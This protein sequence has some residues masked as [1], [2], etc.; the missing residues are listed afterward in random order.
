[1]G[2]SEGDVARLVGIARA[3]RLA[4][5]FDAVVQVVAR[6]SAED[7]IRVG[8]LLAKIDPGAV[9]PGFPEV[10]VVVTG[11]G[12]VG[13]AVAPIA[14]ELVRHGLVPR[15]AATGY[16]TYL[17]DLADPTEAMLAADVTLC[18]LDAQV[19]FA[20]VSTPWQVEDVEATAAR[21]V[22]RMSELLDRFTE[23]AR[24]LVVITTL[25]LPRAHTARLVDHRSR[26]RLGA[27]WRR[28]N[29]DLLALA[30]RPGVVVLDLDPLL[31]DGIPATDQRL[32]VHMGLHYS[33]ALLAAVAREVGHLARNAV[34]RTRKCLV[35]DL[36]DTLWSGVLGEVGPDGVEVGP[37]FAELQKVIRQLGAQGV[38][39]AVASKNDP[40]PVAEALAGRAMV[41]RAEDFVRVSASWRPK[42][43]VLA[44]LAEDLNLGLDSLVFVDDNAAECG[45][46]AR[47]LPDVRVVELSG[48]PAGH[49][50]ALLADGWFDVPRLSAEDKA[51]P[52]AYR[53]DLERRELRAGVDSLDDYLTALDVH[54][55]L[56]VATPADVP[57]LSQLTLRTNQFTM[58][59]TRL[60]AP[61]VAA[62]LDDP[63][64]LVVA[65]RSS[66]RFGDNGLVGAVFGRRVG[67]RLRLEN[68]LLSCRVFGRGI[69]TA[70]LSLVVATATEVEALY[71]PSARN[72]GFADFYPSHGFTPVPSDG[73]G[74]LYRGLGATPPVP[75]H[76]RVTARDLTERA[77]R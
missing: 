40:G 2:Q 44:E 25:P 12:T 52:A 4:A 26:A 36:D 41:L 30:E 48:D 69:E 17:R 3:G 16:D 49:V 27:V 18:L 20:E 56:A 58:T 76:L 67:D 71:V 11:A 6:L 31:G 66:D 73:P 9:P 57:R 43:D 42:P 72:G 1:M 39:L 64:A 32:A 37:A 59:T 7:R 51:R 13:A 77:T 22:R 5:E 28:A 14:A 55:D 34:G 75:A 70:C 54:V 63:D 46:V 74:T 65:I 47:M 45:M 8:P 15:C 21:A 33:P 53:A 60:S 50:A 24:G 19:V 23:R 10:S 61:E 62:L 29:A 68:F 35:V 38:L